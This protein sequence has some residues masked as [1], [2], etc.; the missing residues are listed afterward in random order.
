MSLLKDSNPYV[1]DAQEPADVAEVL[2]MY[3]EELKDMVIEMQ[4]IVKRVR[5]GRIA[6][7]AMSYWIGDIATAISKDSGWLGQSGV[8]LEETIKEIEDL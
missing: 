8:T 7:R 2:R 3:E 4:E 1:E 6:E 5:I